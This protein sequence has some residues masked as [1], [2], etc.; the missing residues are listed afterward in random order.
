MPSLPT[1]TLINLLAQTLDKMVNF[2][3][4][5]RQFVKELV[6]KNLPQF[7][8]KP[9]LKP[10]SRIAHFHYGRKVKLGLDETLLIDLLKKNRLNPHTV[11][12]WFLLEYAPPDVQCLLDEG[13]VSLKDAQKQSTVVRTERRM[14]LSIKILEEIR[15]IVKDM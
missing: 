11:Y 8:G 3:E 15:V 9:L 5:R 2:A 1:T 12:R 10:L 7:A 6:N 4:E 13:K 14:E